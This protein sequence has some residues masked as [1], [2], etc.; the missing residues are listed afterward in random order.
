LELNVSRSVA[1]ITIGGD[2]QS[3]RAVSLEEGKQLAEYYRCPFIETSA[4]TGENVLEAFAKIVQEMH[5]FQLTNERQTK[6]NI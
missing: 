2:L 6:V 1:F 3:R 4:E 5:E